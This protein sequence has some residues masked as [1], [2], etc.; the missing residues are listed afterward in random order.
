VTADD[1]WSIGKAALAARR[2]VAAPSV[3]AAVRT[4]VEGTPRIER[5]D[6]ATYQRLREEAVEI[7]RPFVGADG[8]LAAPFESVLVAASRR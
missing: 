2:W 6:E 7:W 3:D 1:A 5:I 4:E 8:S